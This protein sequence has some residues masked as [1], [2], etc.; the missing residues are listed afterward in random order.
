[1]EIPKMFFA[2]SRRL[3][4]ASVNNN[5]AGSRGWMLKIQRHPALSSS[6][7]SDGGMARMAERTQGQPVT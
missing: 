2:P 7:Q 6:S 1:M 3:R 5:E 4:R